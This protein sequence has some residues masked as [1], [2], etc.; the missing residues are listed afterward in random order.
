M[1]TLLF[2]SLTLIVLTAVFIFFDFV[3][4]GVD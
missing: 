4:K 3:D 1:E 2:V